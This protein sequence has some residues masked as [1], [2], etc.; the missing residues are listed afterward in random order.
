MTSYLTYSPGNT[1]PTLLT[2]PHLLFCF[3]PFHTSAPWPIF[4]VRKNHQH[5]GNERYR[6]LIEHAAPLYDNATTKLEKTQVIAAVV[7][8]V[9]ADARDVSGGAG[10]GFVKNDFQRGLWYEIGDDKARDK[11]GHAIR[12]VIDETKKKQKKKQKLKSKFSVSENVAKTKHQP[13]TPGRYFSSSSPEGND[14][15]DKNKDTTPTSHHTDRKTKPTSPLSIEKLNAL[16]GQFSDSPKGDDGGA[17]TTK[18]SNPR[19]PDASRKHPAGVSYP[20]IAAGTKI[21]PGSNMSSSSSSKANPPTSMVD[22]S[23]F[24]FGSSV[25]MDGSHSNPSSL[26]VPDARGMLGD[27]YNVQRVSKDIFDNVALMGGSRNNNNNNQ[28]FFQNQLAAMDASLSAFNQ[29]KATGSISQPTN[30]M[31]FGHQTVSQGLGGLMSDAFADIGT[32]PG[33]TGAMRSSTSQVRQNEQMGMRYSQVG[34]DNTAMMNYIQQRQQQAFSGTG[35]SS[36]G[37]DTS[38]QTVLSQISSSQRYLDPR[39]LAGSHRS[40]REDFGQS[41]TSS[42]LD[43]VHPSQMQQYGTQDLNYEQLRRFSGINASSTMIGTSLMG[44]GHG[45]AGMRYSS[46]S[47]N[48]N[49]FGMVGGNAGYRYPNGNGGHMRGGQGINPVTDTS[50]AGLNL[51]SWEDAVKRDHFDPSSGQ[52]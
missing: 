37:G 29:S 22:W 20:S 11:V 1:K 52:R 47:D 28:D 12:R 7:R 6:K 14:K 5:P 3:L 13:S 49:N 9:R 23:H 41:M 25:S 18:T 17:R 44:G 31:P 21:P 38:N 24:T 10:G 30:I 48:R 34:V 26:F 33:T 39:G 19:R 16:M 42:M 36:H 43:A 51:D 8:K 15:T 2:S 27:E 46:S 35:T 4:F 32:N 45:A 50:D 40:G